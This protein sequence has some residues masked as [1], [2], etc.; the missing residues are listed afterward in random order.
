MLR[1]LQLD[2]R[3]LEEK[4]LEYQE[5]FPADTLPQGNA[6]ADAAADGTAEENR[7]LLRSLSSEQVA[8]YNEGMYTWDVHGGAIPNQA[9]FITAPLCFRINLSKP[10]FLLDP[11]LLHCKKKL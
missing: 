5:F 2:V 3:D 6:A 11:S 8:V 10:P 7:R 4:Q 1:Q 9:L